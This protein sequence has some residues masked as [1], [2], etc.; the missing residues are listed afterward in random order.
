MAEISKPFLKKLDIDSLGSVV[1]GVDIVDI[2]AGAAGP[3][4]ISSLGCSIATCAYFSKA[5]KAKKGKNTSGY[6][7]YIRKAKN[8]SIAVAS[9]LSTCILS[10]IVCG[11]ISN[12]REKDARNS[13]SLGIS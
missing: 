7:K 8:C 9:T 10:M 3:M 13:Q 12:A 4:L 5:D 11:V 1:G 2:A 6:N